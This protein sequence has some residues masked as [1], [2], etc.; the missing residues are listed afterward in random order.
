MRGYCWAAAVAAAVGL[1]AWGSFRGGRTPG[2]GGGPPA[3]AAGGAFPLVEA[4]APAIRSVGAR[5]AA[6]EEVVRALL[7]EDC[8]L[9]EAAARFR[10]LDARGPR[11][12][13][14]YP[15]RYAGG[16]EAEGYCWAVIVWAGS[17]ARE[18]EPGDAV[19][20]AVGRLEVELEGHCLCGTLTL[21]PPHDAGG[22]P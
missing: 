4:P 9:L 6:K 1:V 13:W 15:E 12:P 18:R 22:G 21:P 20:A 19:A 8:T 16:D 5:M 10:E 7:A 14:P 17:S 3:R 2:D 11:Q